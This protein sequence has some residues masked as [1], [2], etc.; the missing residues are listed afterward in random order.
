MLASQTRPQTP[1]RTL[2]HP[3]DS[4]RDTAWSMCVILS[5]LRTA[6]HP[7]LGFGTHGFSVHYKGE[8]GGKGQEGEA[9]DLPKA[10]VRERQG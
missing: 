10:L 4:S 1:L 3:G 2:M 7:G 8:E 6:P 5:A 9:S